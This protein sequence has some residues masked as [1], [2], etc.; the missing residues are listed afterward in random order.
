KQDDD[1]LG[2]LTD[3][4][5]EM[6][7]QI[8]HRDAALQKAHDELEHRVTER[9]QQLQQEVAERKRAERALFESQQLY[10]LMAIN[11]SD[12]LYVFT[13]GEGRVEWFGQVDKMLGCA[14][15]AFPRTREAW[16]GIIHPED[17][18]G[19]LAANARSQQTGEAFHVEYR[20]RRRDGVWLYW[21]DRGRP[22]F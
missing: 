1:E 17:R 20:V 13:L 16:M 12:L 19:F 4:F 7:A 22:I 9:T 21:S 3:R 11:A 14:D 18:G 5:N 8:Q 10:R 6:L 15:G 2:R